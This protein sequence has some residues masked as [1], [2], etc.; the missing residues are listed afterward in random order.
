MIEDV[1]IPSAYSDTM[2]RLASGSCSSNFRPAFSI[3]TSPSTSLGI[4]D[5]AP[6]DLCTQVPKKQ[7]FKAFR[8]KTPRPTPSIP[9]QSTSIDPLRP[10][11]TLDEDFF[12]KQPI[13]SI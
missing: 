5:L 2:C 3:P 6:V 13:V 4:I 7:N 12:P 11:T 9:L 10:P 8:G 1:I